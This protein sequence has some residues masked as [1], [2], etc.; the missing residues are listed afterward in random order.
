MSGRVFN[1]DVSSS[2]HTLPLQRQVAQARKVLQ[3]CV[4][5]SRFFGSARPNL[6]RKTPRHREV[7]VPGRYLMVVCLNALSA[8]SVVDCK[9]RGEVAGRGHLGNVG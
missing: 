9:E 2:C 8:D 6:R 5:L 7:G 1:T 3:Q 4:L